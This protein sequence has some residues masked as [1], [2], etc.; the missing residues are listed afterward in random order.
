M[1]AASRM[2]EGL[3]SEGRDALIAALSWQ[4]APGGTVLVESGDQCSALWFVLHG[5]L[6]VFDEPDEATG[7]RPVIEDLPVGAVLGD[8]EVQGDG[9][10]DHRVGAA[11]DTE[12]GVVSLEVFRALADQHPRLWKNLARSLLRHVAFERGESVF[13]PS[14]EV[15]A[16]VPADPTAPLAAFAKRLGEAIA[17]IDTVEYIAADEVE[18]VAGPGAKHDDIDEWDEIDRSF[19]RWCL[20]QERTHRYVLLESDNTAT[21][22]TWR[23]LR[24]AD[25]I[26]VLANA[27]P[28]LEPGEVERF[29]AQNVSTASVETILILVHPNSKDR[30]TGTADWLAWRPHVQRVYHVCIGDD[31]HMARLARLVTD[32][33]VGLVLGGG[34]ARGGAHLGAIQ[35]LM[36]VGVPI[37]LVGGTSAGAGVGALVATEVSVRE[38]TQRFWDGFVGLAPF[39]QYDLP[40]SSMIRKDA[41]DGLARFLNGEADVEDL[42]LPWFAVS[43]DIERG[44]MVV[45]RR[46]RVW[47]GVR[48]T[49]ALP[50]VLPPLVDRGRV[51]VDGGVVDNTPVAV[52]KQLHRGATILV[53]VSPPKSNLLGDDVVDLPNNREVLLSLLHPMLS[54]RKAPNIGAIV[55]HTMT[56]SSAARG[57]QAV[58]DLRIDPD[59]RPYGIVEFEAMPELIALGYNATM[60]ALEAV[61]AD[62]VKLRRLGLAPG[63]IPEKLPRKVVPVWL[64]ETRKRQGALVGRARR[65]L[66]LSSGAL[67][68]ATLFWAFLIGHVSLLVAVGQLVSLGLLV[69]ARFLRVAPARLELT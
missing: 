69:V 63:A 65:A 66:V 52:M 43:C 62:D 1:V 21:P 47:K 10:H 67:F 68:L 64:S 15:L 34:G 45:H 9:T 6:R 13:R 20:E 29:V 4:Y 23:C 11:Q 53:N 26:F 37:D 7:R 27:G 61:R 12:V 57:H 42:W 56:L 16:V 25:R 50:G 48:A 39:Q 58:P 31:V 30:P 24:Q 36:E 17:R 59:V 41:I 19:A 44:E 32:R 38:M 51:L 14:A 18:S 60:E 28:A 2:F 22:W 46:G 49:T 8:V 5:R 55:V 54:P 33:A 35:A 3:E 40:Y